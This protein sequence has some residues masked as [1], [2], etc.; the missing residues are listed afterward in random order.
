MTTRVQLALNATDAESANTSRASYA[1]FIVEDPPLKLVLLENAKA[2]G[3]LDHLSV[4]LGDTV[5]VE[6]ATAAFNE[7]C[8]ETIATTQRACC[9]AVQDKVYVTAPH[10]PDRYVGAPHGHRR[11]P[12]R[13]SRSR[14]RLLRD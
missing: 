10:G 14:R 9:H 11:Q 13:P 12:D 5:A 1:N 8:H 7:H 2:D 6:A 3:A 4:E